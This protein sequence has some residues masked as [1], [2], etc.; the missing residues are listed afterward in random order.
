MSMLSEANLQLLLEVPF[1]RQVEPQVRSRLATQMTEVNFGA[2]HE[3]L[4]VGKGGGQL[5]LISSGAVKVHLQ[6]LCLAELGVGSYFGEI[7]LFDGGPASASVTTLVPTTCLR[8]DRAQM[9]QALMATPAIGLSLLQNLA[10]RIRQ[11][12]QRLSAWVRGLL[13]IAWA[14]QE[15]SADEKQ[16]IETLIN[17][18]LYP[19]SYLGQLMPI[20]AADLAAQLGGDPSFAENFLRMAMIVALANGTYSQAE[21]QQL[22]EFCLALGRPTHLL[23]QL[24]TILITPAASSSGGGMGAMA[25]TPPSNDL[26][27]PVRQWLDSVDVHSPH[28]AKFLC[29]LIPPQCPFERD[30]VLFGHKI[31]HI[32]PMCKLN[33]F[34]EQV[35]G[36]RFR[37]LS[38]LADVCH[39]DITPYI[40]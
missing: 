29:K 16:V 1:L 24:Q 2:G 15:Y 40:T 38:Y 31:V 37:A 39:E 19:Q 30:I 25:L 22:R 33:P 4:Q 36:L 17:K 21:D 11:L 14:D 6:D 28:T 26:L 3:I 20:S 8:L 23:D 34:Y 9:E 18:E 35:V 27:L 12:D 13:T 32:P 7:S 10:G 5:Y